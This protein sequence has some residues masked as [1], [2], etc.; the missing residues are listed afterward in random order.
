MELLSQVQMKTAVCELQM[1]RRCWYDI[2]WRK[3]AAQWKAKTQ[4]CVGNRAL[5]EWNGV[6]WR[7][8]EEKNISWL[9]MP[10]QGRCARLYSQAGRNGKVYNRHGSEKMDF[11]MLR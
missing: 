1:N 8:E 3:W 9:L 5:G 6:F 10:E 7:L 4:G 11:E 2:A